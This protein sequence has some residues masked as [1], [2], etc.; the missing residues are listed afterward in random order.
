MAINWKRQVENFYNYLAL[1]KNL[2]HNT[3]V[4][5]ENDL[6]RYVEFLDE[7]KIAAIEDVTPKFIES[8]TILLTDLGLSSNSVARN[9]SAIRS[10]HKYLV[11][12][13][14]TERDPTELLETPRL[15]RKLPEVLSID[16]VLEILEA[17]DTESDFG[18]RDRTMLEVM[19]GAG[20]R[21]SEI[22][23]MRVEGILFDDDLLRIIG[24]GNKERIVPIGEQGMFWLKK[25]VIQVR[26]GMTKGFGSHVFLNR[27]G[28]S[29]SR[30]GVWN[31]VR[32]YALEAAVSQRVYPHIFRHSFATHLLENG[33]DL[34]AVQEMLG[35]S[36]ISTTQ[37]YTH[38]SQTYLKQIYKDFHPRS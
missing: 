1:E 15:S 34:R 26:P 29:L 36:D 20:L 8:F 17:P 33:A 27:F 9:F 35:H 22:I 10:F 31:I 24:K 19:Y 4:S 37:I 25:Y 23:E 14:Q 7:H 12:E 18:V 11:L 13:R 3:L 21:V 16:T 2:S 28:R 38:V 30:M 5:Y 32:K 6:K